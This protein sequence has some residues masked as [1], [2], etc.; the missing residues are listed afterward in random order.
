MLILIYFLFKLVMQFASKEALTIN[1]PPSFPQKTVAIYYIY[2][3]QI[4]QKL[5]KVNWISHCKKKKKKLLNTSSE[6]TLISKKPTT[7]P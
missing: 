5:L 7:S 3:I 2:N 4:S 6:M 1:I